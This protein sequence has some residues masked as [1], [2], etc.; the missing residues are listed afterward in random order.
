MVSGN[1][2]TRDRGNKKARYSRA[3]VHFGI[4]SNCSTLSTI[5]SKSHFEKEHGPIFQGPCRLAGSRS[6]LHR[7]LPPH[8]F[9]PLPR[10][11]RTNQ[12]KY[13]APLFQSSA[14]SPR[15]MA[16]LAGE[17]TFS[18]WVMP[19]DQTANYKPNSSSRIHQ[20]SVLRAL[21][22]S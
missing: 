17:N 5:I 9:I 6:T 19:E 21:M 10:T 3:S 14:I 1:K 2:G 13:D 4:L 16:D 12:P 18:F 22:Q 8:C 7:N 15:V 20:D 11:I